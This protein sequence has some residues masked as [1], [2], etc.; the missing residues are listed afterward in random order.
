MNIKNQLSQNMT[1]LYD[2]KF[3]K[4]DTNTVIY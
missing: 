3:K 1:W 4:Q 2:G